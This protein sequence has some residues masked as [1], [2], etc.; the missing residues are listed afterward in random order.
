MILANV[1]MMRFYVLSMHENGAAKATVYNFV[2]NYVASIVIGAAV[3]GEQ[4]SLRLCVGVSFVL[5]GTAVIS[6][7]QQ[8]GDSDRKNQ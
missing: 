1:L 3:F 7:C 5:A 2:V 8:Q 6:Q 4:V